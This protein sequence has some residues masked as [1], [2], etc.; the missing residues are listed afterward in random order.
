MNCLLSDE[1]C[2]GDVSTP[3]RCLLFL[4][5]VIACLGIAGFASSP[6]LAAPPPNDDIANAEMV[7]GN[8]VS[9]GGT[10]VEATF[11]TNE[12]T[13][14]TS[15]GSAWYRWTA[16]A[17][18]QVTVGVSGALSAG[19]AV[20]TGSTIPSLVFVAA[21]PGATS[22]AAVSGT[23][24]YMS[25]GSSDLAA[26]FTLQLDLADPSGSIS[27]TVV[28]TSS[29]PLEGICVQ[30]YTSTAFPLF[31]G[32]TT[33]TNGDYLLD[34]LE[35]GDFR[36]AF[37]DC[38]SNNVAAEYYNDKQDLASADPVT[39]T[40]GNDTGGINAELAPA[41]TISG[42]LTGD[43]SNPLDN[44]CITVYDSVGDF[45]ASTNS[46][47]SGDYSIGGLATGDYRLRFVDCLDNNNVAS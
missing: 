47:S 9:V 20:H 36:L 32:T 22:F 29:D 16:P 2:L 41:G 21:A 28:D 40:S 12:N 11:E 42:N 10:L 24:Y 4:A 25:V 27:G 37:Y 39:V 19:V 15:N 13:Y 46:D 23:T 38:A 17:S 5:V 35:A 18:G 31:P 33:D 44:M 7:S 14:G 8:S 6:A 3:D 45:R 26:P 30:A 43:S 34:G 1:G